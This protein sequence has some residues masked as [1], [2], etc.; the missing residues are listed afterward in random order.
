MKTL[1]TIITAVLFFSTAAFAQNTLISGRIVD[2]KE[3]PVE[4]A[5]VLLLNPS[6]TTLVKGTVSD[7]LGQ[8]QFEGVQAGSY[9]ISATMVGM[10]SVYSDVFEVT[11]GEATIKLSALMLGSSGVDLDEVV[12]KGQKPFME[13]KTDRLVMNVESSPVAAGNNA[14]E[15]LA[16]APGVSLDQDNRISLKGKQ[17][18]LVMIDGKN[19]YMSTEEVVRMLENMPANNVE[20]IEIIHNPS[21]KYDAA[22]NAGII[23][24]KLKKDK[25]L[26]LNGNV[27]LSAGMGNFPKRNG[28]L[29][30]NYRVKDLNVFGSYSYWYNKRFQDLDIFRSIPF[31]GEVTFFDQFNHQ[32]SEVHSHRYRFGAD[33][34]VGEKTTIGVLY[35]GRSGSWAHDSQNNTIITGD[36]SA[37]YSEVDAG[38]YGKN[39]WENYTLN[40]NLRHQFNQEGR[41]LTFDADY[42]NF[43]SRAGNDYFN[44]F[45]NGEKQQVID[46]NILMADDFSG[47][48]IKAAKLDYTHPFSNGSRLE[49][50]LKSSMVKTDNNIRFQ[51]LVDG[52]WINDETRTNQFLYQEDIHAAYLN[53]NT[54]IKKVTL[55]LG[56][57]AELTDALG[58][59]VT[60]NESFER[61]YFSLFPSVSLSHSIKEDHQLS[62]SYSRRI[63]RPSYQDLNPFIYFLDQFTFGRGNTNLGP[64][65]ADN[66]GINYGYKGRYMINLS[67]GHTTDAIQEVLEQDDEQK[68]TF[69]TYRNLATFRNYSIT[70]SAPVNFAEWWNTR[71]NFSGFLNQVESPFSNEAIDKDQTSY[72]LNVSNN[73]QLPGDIKAQ[74]SGNYQSKMLWGIFEI[75]PRWSLDLGFSKSIWNGKGSVRLNVNDI[76]NTNQTYIN[77]DQGTMNLD[78]SNIRESRRANIT[79]TY[80]FGNKEVKPA[81]RRST[82]TEEEQNRVKSGN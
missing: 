36:N 1:I 23:N 25:N 3:Q 29:N 64:E 9:L 52:E 17:G 41:E 10:E 31:E 20:S 62:Y 18:V 61:D 49:A 43:E 48:I 26:G 8:Y 40:F 77:I 78:I 63:N 47:V 51:Q 55:Q 72:N 11:S 33:Y 14:L 46:P 80:N 45:F 34:S 57:R 13:I 28:S 32:V 68:V 67:Y 42:S 16:K 35:N 58:E 2:D 27:N 73:F 54:K 74:L 66:F 7:S 44:Y 30:L 6:D 19:T 21:S 39:R 79:L 56:L 59:S 81:R 60:L 65:F 69:Q 76:F 71:V 22:G 37:P 70:L 5:N 75:D 15:V 12:V 24:I 53:F 82:A 38:G 50:G 4:F